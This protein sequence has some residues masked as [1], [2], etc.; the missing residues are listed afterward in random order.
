M[1]YIFISLGGGLGALS[2]YFISLSI[3]LFAFFPYATLTV[4]LIGS[5]I[6][7]FLSFL[8]FHKKQLLKACLTTGF[9]GSF[10]TYSAFSLEVLELIQIGRLQTAIIYICLSIGGGILLAFFGSFLARRF[11]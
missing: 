1:R 8:Y 10:T 4:N 3:P 9:L 7:G 2:R 6:L 5:F 11:E